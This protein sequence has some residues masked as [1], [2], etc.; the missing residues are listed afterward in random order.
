MFFFKYLPIIAFREVFK[1]SGQRWA[2]QSKITLSNL[3]T[4]S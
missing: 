4:I 1:R 2:T 3:F